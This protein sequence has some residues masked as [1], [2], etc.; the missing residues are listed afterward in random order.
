MKLSVIIVNYNVQYFLEQCLYSVQKAIKNVATEVFVVD[1]N[2]VD[3]SVLMVQDKFPAVQLILNKENT[4]F[5][6]ANNQAIKIATGEYILLLNPDTVVEEDTFEK[7]IAFMDAHVDAGGLGVKMIDG[8]GKFLPESKRGL[9]T[10]SV[11]FYKI[12]GL[13]SL[14]PKS[15]T[16]GKYHLGFLD[17]NKTHEVAVLSGAFMCIRKSVLDK[18]GML[19]ETFFMYGEDI[20]LSYR[21]ILGGY[22]NYYFPETRIIHYKGE[23]TKKSSINYVFVFYKAMV[24]FAEKY[25]SQNNA[26]LFS[27]LINAAI[28]LRAGLALLIRFL[29]SIALPTLDFSLIIIGLF[30]ITNYYEKNIKFIEGGSYSINLITIAFPAYTLIWI[31]ITYLSGGYDQPIRLIKIIRG[32]LV[33][34]G[35]ILMGYALLP[36]SFR[37]SRAII[38]LGMLWVLFSYI[39][40]RLFLNFIGVR[41]Y[42]LT[43]NKSK[44]IAI[45]GTIEEFER[46]AGLLK[47]T[48]ILTD[49][50]YFISINDNTSKKTGAIGNINQLKEIIEIYKINEIIFCSRD[51]SSQNIINYMYTLVSSEVDFKIAPPE[52]LSIIGSNSIDTAGDLYIINVNSISKSKNKRNKRVFDLLSAFFF[53]FTSPL[54]ILI[55]RNKKYFF[56]NIL[57]VIGGYKSWVGYESINQVNLPKLKPAIF[58]PTD[59]I[60]N[61]V[62]TDEIC[63]R[64]NL[65]YSKEYKVENDLNILL[66]NIRFLG[67]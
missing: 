4:G 21:I 54:L 22:K 42:S 51:I 24:I 43:R 46:V 33:G 29:K 17:E 57:S 40:S 6:Y 58:S 15:K 11:A 55:Q 1:N 67:K 31:F 62:I 49:S 18:I 26:K 19:D 10:P 35:I 27:L 9:P 45:I 56:K 59:A 64:L 50:L 2:S 7:M 3:D 39:F 8:K 52:S 60:K 25:F 63:N 53:L 41:A 23:S 32:V 61:A 5:S 36:E 20:D 44:R 47:Q 34:T 28:Y 12:F 30:F 65:I 38:I 16:F 66:K 14:F 37:F 48:T 13:A